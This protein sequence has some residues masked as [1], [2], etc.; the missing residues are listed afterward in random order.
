[1]HKRH[2]DVNRNKCG[3]TS[4]VE[5][6]A[7]SWGWSAAMDGEVGWEQGAG[8]TLHCGKIV[9]SVHELQWLNVEWKLRLPHTRPNPNSQSAK[10]VLH[11]VV[12]W[13]AAEVALAVCWR[14]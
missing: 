2:D 3:G 13:A 14:R 12:G 11:Q 4:D 6:I 5:A 10:N 1:M 9:S 7:H 8:G